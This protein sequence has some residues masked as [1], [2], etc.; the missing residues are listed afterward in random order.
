M[1]YEDFDFES[2]ENEIRE[3]IHTESYILEARWQRW[4]YATIYSALTSTG[5][6]IYTIAQDIN[7]TAF[8]T[9]LALTYLSARKTMRLAEE[10]EDTPAI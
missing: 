5:V 1:N 9:G 10:I 7:P 6:G 2:L 4:G 3:Q 8:A